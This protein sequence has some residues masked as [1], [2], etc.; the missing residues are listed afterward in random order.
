VTT[1]S[2][3][4]STPL[5]GQMYLYK[6]PELLNHEMHGKLGLSKPERPFEFASAARVIPLTLP[7]L[8]NAHMFYPVIFTDFEN[9][10]PLAVVG[11][12]DDVNLFVDKDGLWEPGVYIPAYVRCYPFALATR[13]DEQFAVVIDRAAEAVSETPEQP[14]FDGEK[15][16][17]EMQSFIDFCGRYDMER[18]MT[19]EFGKRLNELGLLVGHQATR[20]SPDG[21]K[22]VIANYIAVDGSKLAELDAETLQEFLKNGYLS[23]IFAH[24]FSLENW[25]RLA[26]RHKRASAQ[27][28]D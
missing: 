2:Q 16:T 17:A 28:Q 19:L 23:S 18:K 20:T 22:E 3:I 7:E 11:A 13:E 27:E 8:A 14:F 4:H 15:V 10:V 5:E 26:Q 1:E 21:E 12:A 6:Q 24:M 9:P 25:P